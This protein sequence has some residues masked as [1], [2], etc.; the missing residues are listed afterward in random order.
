MSAVGINLSSSK[1]SVIEL[2]GSRKD[3]IIKNIVKAE[4]PSNSIIKGEVQNPIIL[5]NGLKEI[6]KK[7]KISDR[8]VFI[9]IANQKVIVKEV[10]IPVVDDI[11]IANSVKYQISD[12]IPIPK[13]NI[14]Y[15]YFVIEKEESFSRL[16]LVGALKSMIDSVVESFKKA[17]LLAQAIDLNCFALYRTID[18]IYELEKNRKKNESNI[19]C[20]VYLGREISI[21]GI[22]QNNNLKYPRFTSTSINS[23]IE[24]IYKE[25][26]KD[27]KYCEEIIDKFDFR[28]LLVEGGIKGKMIKEQSNDSSSAKS[29]KKED[30]KSDKDNIENIDD[31]NITEIMKDTAD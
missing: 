25:I 28:S 31:K 21:I 5:A 29:Q 13:D 22:I 27:N 3:I 14:I 7:Y 8:K 11:E 24:R 9:G 16:M 10:K 17:G 23:F 30:K 4:L 20:I 12:F 19:F 18:Y 6:W 26:K 15:D 1:I 2:A